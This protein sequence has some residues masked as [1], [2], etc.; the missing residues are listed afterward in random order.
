MTEIEIK[1]AKVISSYLWRRYEFALPDA[2]GFLTQ[3]LIKQLDQAGITFALKEE[4]EMTT[5]HWESLF[6][7]FEN[8]LRQRIAQDIEISKPLCKPGWC[9]ETHDPD[10]YNG[11]IWRIKDKDAAITRGNQ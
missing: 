8:H 2:P 7:E 5:A 3:L 4:G 1:A 10:C 9:N 11:I 6:T